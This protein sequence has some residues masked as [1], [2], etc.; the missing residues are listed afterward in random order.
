[1]L[2]L[3]R[4]Q[5]PL[6]CRGAGPRRGCPS[7]CSGPWGERCH[8]GLPCSSARSMTDRRA[9]PAWRGVEGYATAAAWA[10]TRRTTCAGRARMGAAPRTPWGAVSGARSTRGGS[11]TAATWAIIAQTGG[12]R[13]P[14]WA[15]NVGHRRV[16]RRCRAGHP[17]LG[18]GPQTG[19]WRLALGLHSLWPDSVAGRWCGVGGGWWGQRRAPPSPPPPPDLSLPHPLSR[20]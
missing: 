14:G 17:S 5:R 7:R 3:H 18:L 10:T 12:N 13:G 6:E 8:S 4:S 1:M 9:Q 16:E 2:T 20:G 15:P 19:L 11:S